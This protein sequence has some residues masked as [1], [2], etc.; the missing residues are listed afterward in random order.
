M[1][2]IDLFATRVELR[3]RFGDNSGFCEIAAFTLKPSNGFY[4]GSKISCTAAVRPRTDY[5]QL[6]H[7]ESRELEGGRLICQCKRS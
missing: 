6:G 4:T 3:V 2:S 1:E 5:P 7:R